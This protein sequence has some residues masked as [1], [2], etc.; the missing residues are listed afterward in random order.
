VPTTDDQYPTSF[1]AIT[2]S[3][4]NGNEFMYVVYPDLRDY[5]SSGRYLFVSSKTEVFGGIGAGNN[6]FTTVLDI[7][8]NGII[9]N[10]TATKYRFDTPNR[11][12]MI[13]Q[14]VGIDLAIISNG[15]V[16]SV[17]I[18]S[19]VRDTVRAFI[20]DRCSSESIW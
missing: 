10:G 8:A 19:N 5:T 16:F 13:L 4:I 17:P 6:S 20:I 11:Q 15:Q 9:S 1:S 7:D 3:D 2:A 18:D 12:G 14:Q